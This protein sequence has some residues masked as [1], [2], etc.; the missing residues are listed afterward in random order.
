MKSNSDALGNTMSLSSEM[1]ASDK[2]NLM[3]NRESV[4]GVLS[5]PHVRGLATQ[6]GVNINDICGTGKDGRV[7]KED[8]LKY[9]SE[10]GL[11]KESSD[12]SSEQL[13]F[14]KEEKELPP[15]VVDGSCYE[16]KTVQLR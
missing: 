7:L 15:M 11:Y 13:A 3:L 4:G 5:T 1:P 8:V 10:K 9:A 16:D 2:Q 14:L 12:A 6:Y